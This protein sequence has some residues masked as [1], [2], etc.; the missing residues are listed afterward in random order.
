MFGLKDWIIS[1][2]YPNE[3]SIFHFFIGNSIPLIPVKMH[4]R[5]YTNLDKMLIFDLCSVLLFM[6]LSGRN[7]FHHHNDRGQLDLLLLMPVFGKLCSRKL[8]VQNY[9][10]NNGLMRS[11]CLSWKWR[12]QNDVN[13]CQSTSFLFMWVLQMCVCLKILFFSTHRR[14]G[15]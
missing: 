15:N 9:H 5:L 11:M 8:Y 10:R 7:G 4:A 12:P 13:C 3:S 1:S 14:V 6:K 2:F